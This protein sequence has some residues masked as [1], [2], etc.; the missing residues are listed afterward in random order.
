[1]SGSRYS[2]E[3][4]PLLAPGI[5]GL[6]GTLAIAAT[7]AHPLLHRSKIAEPLTGEG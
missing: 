5:L 3:V 1:M 6:A 7:Y 2:K 4:A